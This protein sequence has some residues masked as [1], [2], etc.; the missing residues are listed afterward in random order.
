MQIKIVRIKIVNDFNAKTVQFGPFCR[1]L[2]Q[3]QIEIVELALKHKRSQSGTTP[4]SYEKKNVANLV[5]G[6]LAQFQDF[7]SEISIRLFFKILAK[8]LTQTLELKS[9]D[10]YE[11]KI[12]IPKWLK[13]RQIK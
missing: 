4:L 3:M 8:I 5:T 2:S 1:S 7:N 6:L 13:E 11:R 9:F 10:R 12:S